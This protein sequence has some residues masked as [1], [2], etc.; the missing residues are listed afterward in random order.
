[1]G[2]NSLGGGMRRPSRGEGREGRRSRAREATS[3]RGRAEVSVGEGEE[4]K[5]ISSWAAILFAPTLV[6]TIYG[7]NF[8]NM[9]ELHWAERV[10]VRN[11]ADGSGVYEPVLH[12]QAAGLAAAARMR[13]LDRLRTSESRIAP[14]GAAWGESGENAR[15]WADRAQ[16]LH[17]VEGRRPA[18]PLLTALRRNRTFGTPCASAARPPAGKPRRRPE[19]REGR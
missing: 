15:Q 10:P 2:D 17:L 9:P 6:G 16:G 11:S 12:L 1:M 18:Q 7:M 4:I 19:D 8:D 14:P 3:G 5:K 13:L